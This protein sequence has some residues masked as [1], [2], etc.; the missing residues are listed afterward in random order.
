MTREAKLEKARALVFD[1]RD[2][3]RD[4]NLECVVEEADRLE[5]AAVLIREVLGSLHDET[6]DEL[7]V[8][9]LVRDVAELQRTVYP[10]RSK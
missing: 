1:V 3:I 6:D 7:A 10:E 5:E 9:Q 8:A 4:E 2:V